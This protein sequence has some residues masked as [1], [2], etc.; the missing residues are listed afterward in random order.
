VC[1]C[2]GD[3]QSAVWEKEIGQMRREEEKECEQAWGHPQK[4]EQGGS[5]DYK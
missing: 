3:S 2:G 1:V 4:A 5:R